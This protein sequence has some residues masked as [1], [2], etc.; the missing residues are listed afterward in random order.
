M[1]GGDQDVMNM[2]VSRQSVVT[3]MGWRKVVVVEPVLHLYTVSSSLAGVA[4]TREAL[5]GEI[6]ALPSPWKEFCPP[7]LFLSIFM[8]LQ[9]LLASTELPLQELSREVVTE[10]TAQK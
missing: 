4:T 5:L 1:L 2:R 7:T 10:S 3:V 9:P 8:S 6:Y